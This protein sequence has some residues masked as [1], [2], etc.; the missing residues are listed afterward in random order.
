MS[1]GELGFSGKVHSHDY[2]NLLKYSY[3]LWRD[4]GTL[5]YASELLSVSELSGDYS[6]VKEAAE[7]ILHNKNILSSNIVHIAKKALNYKNMKS[8]DYCLNENGVALVRGEIKQLRSLLRFNIKNSIA[9]IVLA[10]NYLLTGEM[11]K[12]KK[13]IEIAMNIAPTNRFIIRSAARFY[14]HQGNVG[15]AH[16]ILR[17]SESVKYD[18]WI[19]ASEL[20]VAQFNKRSS[21][22]IKIARKIVSSNSFSSFEISELNSALATYEIEAGSN[23]KAREYFIKSLINPNDNSYAQGVWASKE[24]N[25]DRLREIIRKLNK[26][27]CAYEANARKFR[28]SGNWREAIDS[29]KLWSREEPYSSHAVS[30]ASYISSACYGE[31]EESLSLM[32]GCIPSVRENAVIKNNIAFDYLNLNK[33]SEAEKLLSQKITFTNKSNEIAFTATSGLLEY[34]KGNL[35]KGR[36]L[37]NKAISLAQANNKWD[38]VIQ[39][40]LY[41][42][43]EEHRVGTDYCKEIIEY[44]EKVLK[45]SNDKVVLCLYDRIKKEILS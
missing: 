45:N 26:I 33:I 2:S 25:N 5:P 27:P 12:S 28:E 10:R 43:R 13:A 15:R 44:V 40:S 6:N 7:L 37:Y 35:Q 31:Y 21:D 39:A 19:L 20:A 3:D 8:E 11:N 9:W 1:L 30:L 29:A 41:L 42:A 17:N 34:R 32:L 38:Y 18:P 4:K 16:Y 23:K 36:I 22:Y 24:M 14:I